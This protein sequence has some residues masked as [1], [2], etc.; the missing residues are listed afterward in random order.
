MIGQNNGLICLLLF[1]KF[2]NKIIMFL[3]IMSLIVSYFHLGIRPCEPKF[4]NLG[5]LPWQPLVHRV[6]CLVAPKHY[7]A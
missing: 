5:I 1:I 3:K 6:Q 2:V 7:L 4:A